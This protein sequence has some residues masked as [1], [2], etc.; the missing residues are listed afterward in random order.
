MEAHRRSERD[1]ALSPLHFTIQGAMGWR[2]QHMHAFVI[3]GKRLERGVG[4]RTSLNRRVGGGDTFQCIYDFGD[5]WEHEIRVERSYEVKSRRHYSKRLDG[6]RA[7]PPEDAGGPPGYLRFLEIL[8]D[9]AH[10][11]Y[12][13]M[14]EWAR[15]SGVIT[16]LDV[17][18]DPE[19]FWAQG[20]TWKIQAM[21][22]MG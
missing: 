5:D 14:V 1:T 13:A 4:S 10:R 18:I 12:D 20:A 21:L 2:N 16:R 11:E 3:G 8:G 19:D 22:T 15:Q 17:Q 7:C 6:A 9:P